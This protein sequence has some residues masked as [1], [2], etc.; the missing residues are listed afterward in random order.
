MGTVLARLFEERLGLDLGDRGRVCHRISL[1]IRVP[2]VPG[3][4]G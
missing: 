3:V 2:P 4:A 1:R